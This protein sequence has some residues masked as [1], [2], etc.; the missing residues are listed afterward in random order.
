MQNE[1]LPRII[2]EREADW[3]RVQGNSDAALQSALEAR[4][5]ALPGGS[6]GDAARRVRPALEERL[7]ALQAR[8]WEM[9]KPNLRVNGFNY[10]DFVETT[11]PFDEHLDRDI[12]SVNTERV[13]WETKVVERRR[14]KAGEVANLLDDLELRRDAA[15]W[16]PSAEDLEQEKSTARPIRPED[17]PPP[18]RHAEVLETW[19]KTVANFSNLATIAPEQ[20][21][22]AERVQAVQEEI[23]RLP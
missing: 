15:T 9:A 17:V 23:A 4:L 20:L 21:A 10:E 13:N 19:G 5:S 18:P 1:L 11:E 22:R 12:W 6:K 16:A 2:V 8:M 3:I 7:K 14:V